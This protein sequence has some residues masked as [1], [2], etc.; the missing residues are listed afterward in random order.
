LLA[1]LGCVGVEEVRAVWMSDRTCVALG[2]GK[3]EDLKTEIRATGL[4][5][6]FAHRYE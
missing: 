2:V 4:S 1:C 6:G 3:A 5:V